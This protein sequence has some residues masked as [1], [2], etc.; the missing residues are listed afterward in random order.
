MPY[1][2]NPQS[3]GGSVNRRTVLKLLGV[4]AAGTLGSSTISG[5]GVA[6]TA[7]TANIGSS[8]NYTQDV[9][10][11]IVT[12]RFENGDPTNVPEP[13][14]YDED[15]EDLEKYC[16]GDWQGVI[17]R[18]Q[19]GYLPDMGVTAI[20]I[21]P[22]FDAIFEETSSG[23]SYHGY[24][25]Q[26]FKRT[27]SFFGDMSDFE[28]LINVAHNHDIKVILDF[29]PNHTNPT[30]DEDANGFLYDDGEF[31]AEYDN[32]PDGY[33]LFNGGS[34]FESWEDEIY[35]NLYDLASFDL[36]GDE[37][38]QL[39]KD[40]V[41]FWL[42]LGIDG[43]RIDAVAHMSPGWQKTLMDTIYD[44]RPV[45]TF[46]EWFLG[47]GESDQNYY[48]LSNNSGM[49]MLDFRFGQTIREVLGD[50]SAD[51][52]DFDSMITET[53]AN[54]DQVIDQVPFLDNHD[55]DRFRS[56]AD[57]DRDID[58]AL[59][60][61]LTSRGVPKI[62]YGT[63]Q[64]LEG[65]GDPGARRPMP[66]FDKNTNAYQII[67]ALSD[68]RQS[69]PAMAY[70]ETQ[71]R[72]IN[73]DVLIFE[74]TFDEHTVVV[75]INRSRQAWYEITGLQTSLEG[76]T[77]SDILESRLDG[78]DLDVNA[79]GSVD[80]FSF[81]PETV[82]VWSD[83]GTVEDPTLGHVGPTMGQPG[84]TIE[85]SGDGFGDTSGEVQFGDETA[86]IVSWSE[87]T[88]EVEVP[89]ILAGN[90]EV[91]VTDNSGR[92]SNSYE[93]F[94][95]LSGEQ[96]PVRFVAED[97][98]TSPGEDVYVVGDVH[99]L[100][101]WE[102]TDAVGPFFNEIEHEYPDWYYDIS[103]PASMDIEF[104]F[105]IVDQDGNVSWESGDNRTYTTP[106]AGTGE[107]FGDARL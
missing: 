104:K 65:E 103:V 2:A 61:L 35:R 70:G 72:W 89:S 69:N 88:I 63:E 55:M 5:Q 21:S 105:I 98:E 107:Y 14:I 29:I 17:N 68:L 25:V 51:W 11:Q 101:N 6:N 102:P 42:D 8:V 56:L 9:I 59:T 54:H 39:V 28:Q 4:S 94:E 52:N 100:G 80:E 93:N 23:T 76:G 74:R 99:E 86:T 32:D 27:N 67:A 78:W 87:T 16:G 62:Y 95:I 13:D 49:S 19:D 1:K 22:P 79:D 66:S 75:A 106:S 60:I 46:G 96:V 24:W 18:I 73:E 48:D 91:S 43:I 92:K 71:E 20:W 41:E 45:F 31:L 90:Y 30:D 84:H 38:D 97:V 37:A 83:T 82:A 34:N 57:D 10:Y 58:M 3:D 77:Y 15:C 53:A 81:G 36:S 12:D 33:Y 26:D 44:H 7:N 40:A 50:R 85:L 47:A 64:Y